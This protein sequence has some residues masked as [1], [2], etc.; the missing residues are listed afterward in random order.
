MRDYFVVVGGYLTD[1]PGGQMCF[2][3][4]VDAH[5][6]VLVG[7]ASPL[8][9]D[10]LLPGLFSSGILEYVPFKVTRGSILQYGHY[11][12]SR[13]AL[14]RRGTFALAL[15]AAPRVCDCPCAAAF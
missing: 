15:V 8:Q 7:L 11:T 5:C 1:S 4:G 9:L 3:A 12:L 2:V 14:W 10:D 6:L 13:V